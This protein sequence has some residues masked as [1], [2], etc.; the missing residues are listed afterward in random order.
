MVIPL[1]SAPAAEQ[2]TLISVRLLVTL[3]AVS[4]AGLS[5]SAYRREGSRALLHAV[6]GFLLISVGL[7][8]EV[9]YAVLVKGSFFL[10]EVEVVR[11]Q[12]IEGFVVGVG[13]AV[14]LYSIRGY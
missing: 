14:L 12:A 11:L 10:T 7:A 2:W 6:V 4:F 3:V 5:Y 13:F 8:V 1:Q 9:G